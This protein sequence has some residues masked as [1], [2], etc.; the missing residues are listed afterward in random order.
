MHETHIDTKSPHL[1]SQN[2]MET[3]QRI[4][5]QAIWGPWNIW[6]G[7][8]GTLKYLGRQYGDLEIFVHAIWGSK[9]EKV[10]LHWWIQVER[11]QNLMWTE[12]PKLLSGLKVFKCYCHLTRYILDASYDLGKWNLVEPGWL[13]PGWNSH[14]SKSAG[15]RHNSSFGFPGWKFMNNFVSFSF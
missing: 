15:D 14:H 4:F 12:L 5:G 13:I 2:V 11:Y 6:S 9:R 8:M 1:V 10:L 7:N 3:L